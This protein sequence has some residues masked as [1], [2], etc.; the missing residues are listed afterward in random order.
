MK[1]IKTFE[2]FGW[3]NGRSPQ[4]KPIEKTPTDV[5]VHEKIQS[6]PD[7]KFHIEHDPNSTVWFVKENTL[8]FG[9]RPKASIKEILD[10]ILVLTMFNS[11]NGVTNR[12]IKVP[13]IQ[14]ALDYLES[15]DK[16]VGEEREARENTW[17]EEID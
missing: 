15:E 12:R 5:V 1:N 10:G 4:A 17:D 7:G 9:G 3:S 13:S 11:G 16:R 14:R 6:N 8:G 2:L